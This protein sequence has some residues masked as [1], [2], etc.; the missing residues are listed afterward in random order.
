[1]ESQ[2][3]AMGRAVTEALVEYAR[4]QAGMS[5]L[6]LA[7]GTGEPAISLAE[8]VGPQGHVSA[9]DLSPDLLAIAAGRAR[10]RG[11]QN[12]SFHEGDAQA[13]PFPDQSFD[14]A[15]SRFGVMFF[16]DID[17]A[18][19]HL[20][21]VLRPGARAC[22]SAWGS[23]Q[24]PYWQS[25]IGMVVKHVGGPAIPPG[26]QDPFRFSKPGS[27][28]GALR[29][30]GFSMVEEQERTLPWPWPGPADELWEQAQ[31]VAAPFRA[32]L[33]RVPPEM[34]PKINSDVLAALGK[35]ADNGGVH[36]QAAIVM[37]AAVKS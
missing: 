22:F 21:R 3:A 6:D 24:Q 28:S 26:G 34:W 35:Y 9:L 1:M 14:L 11:L 13:L 27:L 33:D 25:T 17:K 36:L 12:I 15:T 5:V 23:F 37:A 32:L 10:D 7:S 29:R 19:R 8:R 31:A 30:G 20:H 2:T 4:P 18:L 16:A